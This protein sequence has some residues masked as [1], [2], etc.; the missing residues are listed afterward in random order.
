MRCT[1][2]TTLCARSIRKGPSR[3]GKSQ[4]EKAGVEK[5]R[6]EVYA[7]T[8]RRTRRSGRNKDIE[9]C[10][11]LGRGIGPA[12]RAAVV[13][14]EAL[15]GR[16]EQ[17]GT[18]DRSRIDV[19][20]VGAMWLPRGAEVAAILVEQAEV[21]QDEKSAC[22]WLGPTKT[23]PSGKEC[24]RTLR[25]VCRS[26]D[27]LLIGT[28]VCPVHALQRILGR[29]VVA[30]FTSKHPIVSGSDGL[31]LSP[32][33]ARRLIAQKLGTQAL[34]EHSLRRMGAQFYERRGVSLSFVE[35]LG[36]WGS[37]TIERY[38]ADALAE[39]ASL[40]PL[41]SRAGLGHFRHT[42]GHGHPGRSWD[43]S[44]RLVGLDQAVRQNRT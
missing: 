3:A 42:W 9:C 11:S 16:W 43:V 8:S 6:S 32:V 19:A 36:R 4:P 10:R 13:R 40:A 34:T 29:Q 39:K 26:G 7:A 35:V 1:A 30:G 25:C 20:V 15:P 31:A 44:P 17:A 12:K 18:A 5:L 2:T 23:N 14:L 38:V 24:Q 21:A 33:K 27:D 28:R 41:G 22:L 37:A